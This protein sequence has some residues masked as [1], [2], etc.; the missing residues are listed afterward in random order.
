MTIPATQATTTV[1]YSQAVDSLIGRQLAN[2]PAV[3]ANYGALQR[4]SYRDIGLGP[5]GAPAAVA[6]RLQFNPERIR[7]SAASVDAKSLQARKCF[8]CPEHQPAEQETVEWG[9][10]AYKIQVNPYPIFPRHLTISSTRHEP[11]RIAGR[12]GHMLQLALDLPGMVVFYNGP[13][14]GAS[15]PDHAHFQAGNADFLPYCNRSGGSRQI[16]AQEGGNS[17]GLTLGGSWY[18]PVFE[19][20]GTDTGV[21]SRMFERLQRALPMQAGDPEPRQN[22]LCWCDASGACRLAVIPR[23][24]HRP[25]CYGDGAGQVVLSPASVDLGG[26]WA[27]PRRQDYDSITASLLREILADVCLSRAQA[28]AVAGRYNELSINDIKH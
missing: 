23:K 12:I 28:R 11:Q 2:W 3:T 21:L 5:D 17:L 16:V 9:G 19:L 15:A 8:L 27:V 22:L 14:C 24:M 7:S 20:R 4:V 6:A 13:L 26:V 10:G 1:N 18:C 25:R